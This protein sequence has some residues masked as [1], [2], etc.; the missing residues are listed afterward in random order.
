MT[1]PVDY[2]GYSAVRVEIEWD[3]S[4]SF[5]KHSMDI[6]G[7][8]FLFQYFHVSDLFL[9]CNKLQLVTFSVLQDPITDSHR[10]ESANRPRADH[11]TQLHCP[12]ASEDLEPN[13]L[14]QHLW[15]GDTS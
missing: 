5:G 6:L 11:T 7:S 8:S 12:L 10:W 3:R 13:K 15:F 2:F 1:F 9:A 4:A 14:H